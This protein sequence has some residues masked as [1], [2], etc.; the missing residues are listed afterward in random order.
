MLNEINK[1]HRLNAGNLLPHR[2]HTLLKFSAVFESL[3][4]KVLRGALAQL[5]RAED[6]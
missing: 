5:V 2:F 4:L 6:S 3:E 1:L